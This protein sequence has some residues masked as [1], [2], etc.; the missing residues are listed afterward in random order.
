M[1]KWYVLIFKSIVWIYNLSWEHYIIMQINKIVTSTRAQYPYNEE[2]RVIL[3][4][5]DIWVI[6]NFLE[7][8]GPWDDFLKYFV[9][10]G[11]LFIPTLFEKK[12]NSLRL[13]E[14]QPYLPYICDINKWKFPEIQGLYQYFWFLNIP[15]IR[16]FPVI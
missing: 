16:K 13:K 12:K 3:M 1:E 6:W 10:L 9:D 2:T 5:F 15:L 14:Y 7:S 4:S 8:L 11:G